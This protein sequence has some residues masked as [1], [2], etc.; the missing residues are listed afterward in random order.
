MDR[1][2]FKIL[3]DHKE[4]EMKIREIGER[5]A[6]DFRGKTPVLIGVLKGA[7][8]FLADLARSI[9]G[10]DMEIDFIG[11]C[12]Y[13]DKTY[14]ASPPEITKDISIDISDRDVIIIEDIID[15]GSTFSFVV[16]HIE[17]KNPAS[18]KICSLVDKRG[19]RKG[20]LKIDYVGFEIESGFVIGYGMDFSEKYRN[21]K[22]ILLFQEDNAQAP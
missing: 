14:P 16:K 21:I 19:R 3:I 5:I 12:S 7:F 17:N 4:I 13:R 9:E 2:Q 18:L 15:T 10:I 6:E 11:V 1:H 22:D 8:M 20:D